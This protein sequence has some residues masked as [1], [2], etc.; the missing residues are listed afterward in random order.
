LLLLRPRRRPLCRMFMLTLCSVN[1]FA[2]NRPRRSSAPMAIDPVQ[3]AP[4]LLPEPTG[5][6]AVRAAIWPTNCAE[7]S[8]PLAGLHRISGWTCRL[9]DKAALDR[10]GRETKRIIGRR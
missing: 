1:I 8:Q 7:G 10:F 9:V 3:P 4:D 2:K 6:A 5:H